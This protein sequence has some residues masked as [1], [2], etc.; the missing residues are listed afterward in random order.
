MNN[1]THKNPVT[2][3]IITENQSMKNHLKLHK[4]SIQIIEKFKYIQKNS[5]NPTR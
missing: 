4:V 5:Y 1:F 3:K 2:Y